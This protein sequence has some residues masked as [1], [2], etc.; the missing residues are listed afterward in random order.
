MITIITGIFT[1]FNSTHLKFDV[2]T[3][4]SRSFY[5]NNNTVNSNNGESIKSDEEVAK[6]LQKKFDEEASNSKKL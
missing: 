3:G 2:T 4:N 1:G 6:E 5:P